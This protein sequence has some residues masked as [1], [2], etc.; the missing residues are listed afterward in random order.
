M[1]VD[2]CKMRKGFSLIEVMV[3]VLVTLIGVVGIYAL[4]PHIIQSTAFNYDRFVAIQLARDGI[5]I[6]RNVRDSNWLQG[7]SWNNGLTGCGNGCQ[8]DYTILSSQDPTPRLVGFRPWSS[9][10][11][12]LEIDSTTGFYSYSGDI[13]TKFKRRIWFNNA[14]GGRGLKVK[15]QVSWPE[16]VLVLEE[17]LYNWR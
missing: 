16:N 11:D 7:D 3:A 5:E 14:D 17:V 9:G 2:F 6:I 8:L 4:V 15:V 10:G 12:F 13:I 1:F